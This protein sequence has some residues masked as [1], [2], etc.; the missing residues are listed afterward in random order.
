LLSCLLLDSK[1]FGSAGLRWPRLR[2]L[3]NVCAMGVIGVLRSIKA[4]E[5]EEKS[6]TAIASEIGAEALMSPGRQTRS[7]ARHYEGRRK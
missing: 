7:A 2:L 4:A 1:I 3:R 5:A 6:G